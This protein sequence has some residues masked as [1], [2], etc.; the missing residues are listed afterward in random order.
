MNFIQDKLDV[1]IKR[2]SNLF[3]WRGQFTPEFVEYVL[4]SANLEKD[5]LVADPFAGSGTVLIES[6][7]KG[8]SSVGYEINPAAYQMAKF[9]KY[10]NLN[11]AER[12]DF[13]F[14]L[15][16]RLSPI[17]SRLNGQTIY[18]DSK[19][20]RTAYKGL[21]DTSSLIKSISDEATS[22]YFMNMLFISEKHKR[23]TVKESLNRSFTYLKEALLNLPFCDA[24]INVLNSD[25][26]NISN[27]YEDQVDLILT[28]PPY[29]NVFNY[30]QNYRAVTEA[31]DY[32]ILGVAHSEFG[33]NRKNRGNRL[34]TVVQYCIDM[35]KSISDFWHSLKEGAK[36][37]MVVGRESNVR[38]TPFYNGQIVEDIICEMGGFHAIGKEERSFGN[39]F[40][41]RIFEDI[42]MYE[43][44]GRET[45]TPT[46][47]T[48]IAEN[49]LRNAQTKAPEEV[50]SDFEDVLSRIQNVKPSPIFN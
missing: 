44:V 4:S 32:N 10:S 37:I 26:R 5:S 11:L 19:D 39:K 43:K 24:E 40:G 9:Y 21:I 18:N 28:S 16:K 41:T 38:K 7:I 46:N 2:R 6:A 33:S 49:H 12:H 42:L 22:A 17:I 34:L 3:N 35:E 13:L 48:R 47:A 1:R 29:I 25:A 36:L 50:L 27:D 8:Y 14:D 15:E 31:F 45:P 30:H 20:Y 23:M